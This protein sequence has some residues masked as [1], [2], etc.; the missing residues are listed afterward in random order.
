[1][2][3]P[4]SPTPKLQRISQDGATR[5]LRVEGVAWSDLNQISSRFSP[6][7]KIERITW[8]EDAKTCFI[9][10]VS[11]TNAIAAKT[12]LHKSTHADGSTISI[13]YQE[14]WTEGRETLTL[15]KK[16]EERGCLWIENVTSHVTA[17]TLY[18]T[19][20]RYGDILGYGFQR[21]CQEA[22][23]VFA[24]ESQ[25]EAAIS[26]LNRTEINGGIIRI[27]RYWGSLAPYGLKDQLLFEQGQPLGL[28]I[29]I[30]RGTTSP[31]ELD[32][33]NEFLPYHPYSV[34]PYY[35]EARGQKYCFVNFTDVD[36]C[37]QAREKMQG[38]LFGN[39]NIKVNYAT[40][41][42]HQQQQLYIPQLRQFSPLNEIDQAS[43]TEEG[44]S[45]H[46]GEISL[47]SD[48]KGHS[49]ERDTPQPLICAPDPV[50]RFLDFIL[51]SPSPRKDSS[52]PPIEPSSTRIWSPEVKS[53]P[54]CSFSALDLPMYDPSQGTYFEDCQDKAWV[55]DL[56]YGDASLPVTALHLGGPP[57]LLT[58]S[59]KIV[60]SAQV[61][62]S[63]VTTLL[64]KPDTS[65]LKLTSASHSDQVRGV[66]SHLNGLKVGACVT[67]T[68]DLL[69]VSGSH[70]LLHL[71][72]PQSSEPWI[73]GIFIPK[74]NLSSLL[75]GIIQAK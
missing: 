49:P 45:G 37:R 67:Q 19:F 53:S 7:G 47:T 36:N 34:S 75:K 1:M 65:L 12:A 48:I 9:E 55:A 40:H 15:P 32:V 3:L 60:M 33:Y 58:I 70:P 30:P 51:E 24:Q 50:A 46:E 23:V 13:V 69:L 56:I 16:R 2:T 22:V 52:P 64:H 17:T 10:Y 42:P 21:Q 43:G 57:I 25:A 59:D 74:T 63:A 14:K 4:E 61:N 71:D 72:L 8:G 38:R 5:F 26:A 66:A 18:R 41:Q 44:M 20:K 27:Q 68:W 54:F 11:R 62:L 6:F 28:Y 35:T 29:R 39:P 31:S 73:L